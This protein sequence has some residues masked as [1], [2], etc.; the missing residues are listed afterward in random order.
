MPVKDKDCGEPLALSVIATEDV[1]VPA[2]L[3]V[4]VTLTAQ[5]VF[6]AKL[7]PQLLAEMAKS[8]EVVIDAMLTG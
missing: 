6:A 3:G 1:R 7:V 2:A 8:P 4:N 5:N